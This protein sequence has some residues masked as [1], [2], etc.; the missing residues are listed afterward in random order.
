[1]AKAKSRGSLLVQTTPPISQLESNSN[2]AHPI[3][4][5]NFILY[6]IFSF[7]QYRHGK[8]HFSS[9]TT[10]SSPTIQLEMILFVRS[11]I[12]HIFFLINLRYFVHYMYNAILH[13]SGFTAV[14]QTTMSAMFSL[15]DFNSSHSKTSGCFNSTLTKKYIKV[16]YLDNELFW[17]SW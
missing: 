15:Q 9:C 13:N 11:E 1:M 12:W 10:D 8:K 14:N 7:L 16:W 3:I 2:G 17:Q 6:V 5:L 4:L